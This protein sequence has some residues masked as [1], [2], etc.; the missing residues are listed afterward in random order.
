MGNAAL[1]VEHLELMLFRANGVLFGSELDQ[2]GGV[3]KPEKDT[4]TGGGT[5]PLDNLF[6]GN[7]SGSR[8]NWKVIKLKEKQAEGMEWGFLAEEPEDI[9]NISIEDV[10]PL[11]A[12]IENL[13]SLKALW[14]SFIYK[15]EIGLLLDLAVLCREIRGR[16][17]SA[18][19]AAF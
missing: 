15:G 14:G 5:T 7:P 16:K 3:F 12:I 8:A 2:V 13:K 6:F 18:G 19:G 17:A 9:V 10:R 1:G 11:P 4:S